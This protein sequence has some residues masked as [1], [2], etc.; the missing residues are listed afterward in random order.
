MYLKALS[1]LEEGFAYKNR[2]I[3]NYNKQP[4]KGAWVT[5]LYISSSQQLDSFATSRLD[6]FLLNH[7]FL[8]HNLGLV[9][10]KEPL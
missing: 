3:V 6:L 2:V 1:Y 9:S 8:L 10:Y 4:C 7:G 5:P